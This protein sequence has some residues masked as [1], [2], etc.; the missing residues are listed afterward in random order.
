MIRTLKIYIVDPDPIKTRAFLW[1]HLPEGLWSLLAREYYTP[2]FLGVRIF[3]SRKTPAL[4]ALVEIWTSIESLEAARRTPAFS[5]LERFQGK[6]TISTIN[7]GL[8]RVSEQKDGD[9]FDQ[10]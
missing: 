2:G 5:V 6:L 10:S 3:H 1:A 9:P 7:C 8:V 4:F